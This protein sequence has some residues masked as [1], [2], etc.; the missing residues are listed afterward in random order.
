VTDPAGVSFV[1]YRRSRADETEL[2]VRAQHDH[3]IPTWRDVDDLR[4]EPTEEEIVR[5]LKDPRT[6]NALIWATPEIEHS[7]MILRVEIPKIYARWKDR[8]GF[9]V[10]PVAAGGL[11]YD[12]ASALVSKSELLG[13]DDF[14]KWN[15][16]TVE[17]D[18]ISD[19]EASLIAQAVL[20]R[21]MR[22]IEVTLEDADPF[23]I[24]LFTRTRAPAS[25]GLHFPLDWAPRFDGRTAQ[26]TTWGRYLLPALRELSDELLRVAPQREVHAQGLAAVPA[27]VALG[28]AFLEPRKTRLVWEQPIPGATGAQAW[29]LH[30]PPTA[31]DLE[32][33]ITPLNTAADD[34][35]VCVS[36]RAGVEAAVKRGQDAG[37]IP[38]F[39]AMVTVEP[40]E[41][42][43]LRI[44]TPGEAAGAVQLIDRAMRRAQ[45]EYPTAGEIHLFLAV[46]A[47]IAVLLGQKLNAMGP[48]QLYEHIQT[49]RIGTYVPA[50]TLH[51][52]A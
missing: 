18:R 3:G 28:A 43:E 25:S 13:L 34:I 17:G 26:A 16:E 41:G 6:A 45:A 31:G 37:E 39:R 42:G 14:K 23:R 8:D 2:L 4:T 29:W 10:I 44:S 51:P 27:L 40:R 9:F 35:A 22:A 50:V 38:P 11:G 47:G 15:L 30:A 12:D 1:S 36:L 48:I 46:P 20:R 5:I 24:G 21:R 49:D 33:T 19:E 7:P 52:G 32:A